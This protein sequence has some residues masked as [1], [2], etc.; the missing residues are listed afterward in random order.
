MALPLSA[1]SACAGDSLS[2]RHRFSVNLLNLIARDV[3][4][5]YE[6]G[7]GKGLR[8]R[9]E[10]GYQAAHKEVSSSSA[11]PLPVSYFRPV[12]TRLY[13]SAGIGIPLPAH[14]LIFGEVYYQSRTCDSISYR[15]YSSYE[16][17]QYVPYVLIS[18][19][20]NL[21]G[22]KAS[23]SY[24]S[25][26]LAQKKWACSLE[27]FTGW[28]V[29]YVFGSRTQFARQVSKEWLYYSTPA[30][31]DINYFTLTAHI[32]MRIGIDFR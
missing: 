20:L 18:R 31:W 4:I 8:Y 9:T 2:Y 21:V 32:G 15:Y 26:L 11:F 6:Y 7:S 17:S 25:I 19:R 3:R 28:G 10:F 12:E 14:G 5:G 13:A 16:Y 23:Y 22:L 30:K 29:R 27:I 1:Q 24:R